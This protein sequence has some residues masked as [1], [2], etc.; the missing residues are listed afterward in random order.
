M[1][2]LERIRKN[3]QELDQ[4]IRRLEFITR[5]QRVLLGIDKPQ[6]RVIKPEEERYQNVR[7]FT[8]PTIK[9]EEPK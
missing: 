1:D 9:T 6:L 7:T 5:E 4:A 2:R 3:M 8:P